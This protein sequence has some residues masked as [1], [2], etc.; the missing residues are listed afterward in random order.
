MISLPDRALTSRLIMLSLFATTVVGCSNFSDQTNPAGI[1]TT[2]F[3]DRFGNA[4]EEV[5]ATCSD[6]LSINPGDET[7]SLTSRCNSLSDVAS[8]NGQLV[9]SLLMGQGDIELDAPIASR[10]GTINQTIDG[11]SWPMQNCE[12]QVDGTIDFR[13]MDLYDL[14]AEWTERRGKAA[15][16]IDFDF[17]GTQTVARV[18]IDAVADCPS[19]LNQ[20][21]IQKR[22]DNHLNGRHNVRASGM[23]LDVWIPF[24]E[25]DGGVATDL[26]VRFVVNR[27]SLSG[28]DWR[29]LYVDAAE[30]NELFRVQ[31]ETEADSIFENSLSE[32]PAIALDLLQ[33]GYDE[34]APL[35]SLKQAGGQLTLRTGDTDGGHPCIGRAVAES[36]NFHR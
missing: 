30:M 29:K 4:L 23:D 21:L 15:F 33:N 18:T 7:I 2:V 5:F 14:D 12:I 19:G 9:A 26:E 25:E 32:L 28:V 13:G 34:D 27:V 17:E 20:W 16:K 8:T 36:L 24:F 10:V 1:E 31:L 35:C 3:D 22:L 6:P 11:F